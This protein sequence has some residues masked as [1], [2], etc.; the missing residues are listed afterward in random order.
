M[1]KIF[2]MLLVLMA[3]SMVSISAAKRVEASGKQMEKK[4]TG[5]TGFRGILAKNVVDVVYRDSPNTEIKVIAEESVMPYVEVTKSEDML[6]VGIQK[7]IS[8][9][10]NK[11]RLKVEVSAPNVNMFSI[12]GSSDIYVNGVVNRNKLVLGITGSGDIKAER[13][14]AN[15]MT[16][17]ISGRGDIDVKSA[18]VSSELTCGIT[19]SGDIKLVYLSAKEVS[20]GITGSGDVKI[21]SGSAEKATYKVSGSGDVSA[22]N[23]QAGD[24]DVALDGSGDV[25]CCAKSSIACI[26]RG[27]G[28]VVYYGKPSKVNKTGRN[29]HGKG[30]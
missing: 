21:K 17:G 5:I 25:K 24:V 4:V 9:K 15:E 23:L 11:R 26:N 14:V 12:T 10:L 19:G 29:I 2:T 20:V 27:S 30:D 16:L 28:N 18:N 7:G 6:V 13:I 22:I 3:A 1:K 8:I